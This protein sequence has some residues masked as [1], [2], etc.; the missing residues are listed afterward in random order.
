[1][2]NIKP[3]NLADEYESK[4]MIIENS[5]LAYKQLVR[6]MENLTRFLLV[7]IIVESCILAVLLTSVG[8]AK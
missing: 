5:I 2:S 8:F 7:V 1:M 6:K 4:L 3:Q